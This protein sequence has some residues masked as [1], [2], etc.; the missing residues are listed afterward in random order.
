MFG[1]LLS[2]RCDQHFPVPVSPG[3]QYFVFLVVFLFP[4]LCMFSLF[5]LAISF[6]WIKANFLRESLYRIRVLAIS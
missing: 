4:G 6:R 1:G 2:R 3:P 5:V